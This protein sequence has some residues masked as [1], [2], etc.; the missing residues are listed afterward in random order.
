MARKRSPREAPPAS[1]DPIV[2]TPLDAAAFEMAEAVARALGTSLRHYMPFAKLAAI[3][4]AKDRLSPY[5]G[6]ASNG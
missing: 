1:P 6:E 2:A 4:A 5:F 3:A